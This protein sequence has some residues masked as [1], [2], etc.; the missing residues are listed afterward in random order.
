MSPCQVDTRDYNCGYWIFRVMI[1]TR[2]LTPDKFPANEEPAEFNRLFPAVSL[3]TVNY[4]PRLHCLLMNGFIL[5]YRAVY[6]IRAAC[7]SAT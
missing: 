4:R 1:V 5:L 2:I 7:H 3:L 6:R